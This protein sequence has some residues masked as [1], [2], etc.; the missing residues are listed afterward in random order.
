MDTKEIELKLTVAEANGVLNALGQ[1]P[2]VQVST[3]IQKIQQQ[4]AP[5]VQAPVAPAEE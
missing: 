3:L 1:M 5:Q 2:F 4:A